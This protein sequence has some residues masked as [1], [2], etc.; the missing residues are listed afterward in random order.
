MNKMKKITAVLAAAMMLLTGCSSEKESGENDLVTSSAPENNVTNMQAEDEE[1]LVP[2]SEY[3]FEVTGAKENYMVIVRKGEHPDEISVTIENNLY[4]SREYII[5]TPSGYDFIFPYSQDYASSVVNVITNDID[6]TYIPDI[7]QFVFS[8]SQDEL[9]N[10]PSNSDYSVSRFYCIDENGDLKDIGIV[11]PGNEELE[12]E[13]TVTDVLDRTLL[14]HSEPDKFIYEISV[15]DRE[16]Y[17]DDYE[18]IPIERR[19]KIKTL[20]FDTDSLS[21]ISGYEK[22]N[23]DNPLY[24]GYAYWAAAN[25]AA[26]NFIMTTFNVSDYENYIERTNENG[27]SEYYFRIDDSRFDDCD[28]L[29]DYLMTIFSEATATRIFSQAPQ[30]YC[31]I[32]GELYGIVGDGGYDFTLGTLTF[33]G[34]EITDNRMLFRS[35]Q[36]KYDDEGNYTGYTDGG[37]FIIVRQEGEWKVVQYRYPYS[38][39]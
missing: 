1:P 23:E 24:F 26:Q 17:D 7:M 6:D 32:N 16:L 5:N 27:M 28:D 30:K 22:I 29:M 31:D 14:Y 9:D 2:F 12:I 38:F 33:S 8:I 10:N 34:M 3:S 36:E 39:N 18:P 11:T 25:S 15:D 20:T 37:D 21:F 35:R 4:E 13:D 19:V